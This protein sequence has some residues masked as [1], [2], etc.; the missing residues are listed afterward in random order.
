VSARDDYPW[1]ADAWLSD[2][3][4]EQRDAALDEIDRLR[5]EVA[6][7]NRDRLAV[8]DEHVRLAGELGARMRAGYDA[9]VAVETDKTHGSQP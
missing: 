1:L 3:S 7:L 5:A 8:S 9:Q 4:M 2:D 6:A